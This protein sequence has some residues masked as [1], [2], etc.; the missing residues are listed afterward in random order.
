MKIDKEVL[1]EYITKVSL[2]ATIPT[3]NLKF[4]EAGVETKVRNIQ[5]TGMV[6]GLL[7]KE[8]F[9]EYEEIGEIF[10][11]DSRM[12]LNTLKTFSEVINLEKYTDNILKIW[13][14]TRE[15]CI[16]LAEE[17]ICDNLMTKERPDIESTSSIPL[18]KEV[19]LRTTNDMKMLAINYVFFEK[20]GKELTISIGAEQKYDYIKNIIQCEED[21][22]VK[23]G[24]ASGFEDVILSIGSDVVLHLGNDL[25]LIF[26]DKTENMEV[27]TFLSPFVPNDD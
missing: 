2:S 12:I 10:I 17:K 20:I 15:V 9:L 6:L 22:D 3:L 4:T 21:G 5:N 13:D 7:K 25:P 8:A 18:T 14:E 19:L 16:M 23:V 26:E 11:K 27:E 1:K 24:V